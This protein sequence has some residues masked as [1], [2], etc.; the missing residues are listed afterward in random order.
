M[1]NSYKGLL[2]VKPENIKSEFITSIHISTTMG[3]DLKIN[4]GFFKR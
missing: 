4:L 3:F 1:I 2:A